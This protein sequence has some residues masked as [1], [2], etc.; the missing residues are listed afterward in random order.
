MFLIFG[1][2][3]TQYLLALLAPSPWWVPDLVLI[4]LILGVIAE[5]SRW[6]T[7]SLCAGA[8]HALAAVRHPGVFF[9]GDLAIGG[10]TLIAPAPWDMAPRQLEGVL[11]GVSSVA[12][13]AVACWLDELWS[14]ALV[15]LMLWRMSLTLLSV[16]L[17]RRLVPLRDQP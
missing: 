17:V 6:L 1:C 13:M 14:M 10:L 9:I 7:F 15:G 4:G 8:F 2:A 11:V 16:G 12:L 5:P 3:M